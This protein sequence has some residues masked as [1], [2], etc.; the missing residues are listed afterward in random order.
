LPRFHEGIERVVKCA[1]EEVVALMCSEKEPLDCH[2]TVLICRHLRD[3]GLR[4]HHILADGSIEEH[5]E[6][7]RRMI[8]LAGIE[9]DLFHSDATEA[10]LID[11]SY[12]ALGKEIAYR[13]A[14]SESATQR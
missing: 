1:G 14:P 11:R 4:I 5:E 7:E 2:R 13:A 9:K 8:R 12:E 10:G 3:R 6:T